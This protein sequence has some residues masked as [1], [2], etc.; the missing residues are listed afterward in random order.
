MIEKLFTSKIRVKLLEYF[1][2]RKQESKIREA[3]RNTGI[4][5]SADLVSY[6]DSVRKTRHIA[7]YDVADYVSKEIAEEAVKEAEA[8]L[9]EIR[10]YVLKIR[11]ESK[12]KAEGMKKEGQKQRKNALFSA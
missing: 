3:S 8:F 12:K 11:T 1:I 9:Q 10:T 6:F 2:L 5:V 4:N 7:V